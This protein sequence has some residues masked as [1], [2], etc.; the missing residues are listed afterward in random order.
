MR[1]R[2]A[3]AGDVWGVGGKVLTL[4]DLTDVYMDIFL[5]APAAGRVP[6]GAAARIVLRHRARVRDSRAC[7]L[8]ELA[9]RDAPD[10]LN[11]S[12]PFRPTG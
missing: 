7:L 11:V 4:V 1:Y 3:E 5:S 8:G 9:T 10:V 6:L 12:R 2:L